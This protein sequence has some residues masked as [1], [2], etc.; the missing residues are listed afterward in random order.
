[1]KERQ[2][3]LVADDNISIVDIIE[4]ILRK[5]GYQI[6]RAYDGEEALNMV[7]SDPPD[8]IIL[9]VIM[10]KINGLE[11]LR[12][13]KSSEETRLIPVVMLTSKDYVE[14]RVAGYETGAD[15]YIA[16]P[17]LAKELTVRIN[18]LLEKKTYLNKKVELEKREALESIVDGVAHEIRNPVLAIGGFARRLR[19]KLSP[20][21]DLKIYADHIIHEVER[22][23]NMVEKIINL[24][25]I[26]VSIHEHVDLKKILA[27][28]LSKFNPVI[29]EKKI[30]VKQQYPDKIPEITGDSKNLREAF[31][32]IIE[33]SI[34]AVNDEG[35]I[36]LTIKVSEKR[37]IISFTDSGRGIPKSQLPHVFR[38]FYTSKMTGAGM[39]LAL[40]NH[41]VSLHGGDIDISS[42]PGMETRVDIILHVTSSNLT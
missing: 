6:I 40:A 31:S 24:K 36:T 4:K 9:D 10:P 17:F 37:V 22:L 39:G 26:A 12:R 11:V 25:T 27:G 16:K 28:A 21:D 2:K 23:E 34:E 35:V 5:N 38:P 42:T 29:A 15:D 33:N 30:T 8:L 41:I 1:M 3:V 32:N 20:G 18:G 14:D 19:D 7:F 13:L